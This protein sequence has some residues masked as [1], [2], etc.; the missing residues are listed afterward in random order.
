MTKR[1]YKEKSL[2]S[3]Q[4]NPE[5]TSGMGKDSIVP[6]EVRKWNWGAFFLN[7]IWGIGN[8]V[9]ISLLMFIPPLFLIMPFVLGAKGSEWAWRKRTWRSVEEFKRTQKLWARW[10][11]GLIVGMCLLFTYFMRDNEFQTEHWQAFLHNPVVIDTLGEPIEKGSFW[12]GF[13]Q[14]KWDN[15]KACLYQRIAVHGGK[16]SGHYFLVL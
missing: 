12:D 6:E 13:F 11:I 10:G 5:N 2:F 15:G 1:E 16:T 8:S 4:T 9:W 7:W 3:S 14:K